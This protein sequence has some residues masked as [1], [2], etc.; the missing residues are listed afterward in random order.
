MV[1]PGLIACAIMAAPPSDWWADQPVVRHELPAVENEAW[2]RNGIDHFIL[3][4]LEA[5]ELSPPSDAD[6]RTLIRRA[7]YDLTGLPPSPEAVEA[8]VADDRPDAYERLIEELLASPQYGVKWG[9]H[10]LDRVRW[11][12]TDGYERD[13]FKPGA[14]RYRDWVVQAFNEDM[15]YDRFITLQLAGDE[16]PDRDFSTM[17]ATGFL[18]LGIRDDEPTDPETAIYDDLDGM[19]DTTC[20]AT[21]AI[22]MGCAR[23]HD[24][25]KD[26]IPQADYYRMLSFFRGL[27]P[28]RLGYGNAVIPAHYVRNL[29]LNFGNVDSSEI[30]AWIARQESLRNEVTAMTLEALESQGGAGSIPDIDTALGLPAAGMLKH[31]DFEG[32]PEICE[33]G[34][35]GHALLVNA[36]ENSFTIPRPVQND[37]TISFSFRP[38]ADGAGSGDP[39][40]FLGS[41]LVD[42]EISGIVND[43]GISWFKGGRVTAGVGNPETFLTSPAGLELGKWHHAALTRNRESGKVQLWVDG[44]L[45]DEKIGGK[46]S[47]D[48]PQDLA[49]GRMYPGGNPFPGAIDE[50]RIYDRVLTNRELLSIQ[51]STSYGEDA[52]RLVEQR[53][54]PEKADRFNQIYEERLSLKRPWNETSE[55]LAAIEVG[56]K[57]PPTHRLPRGN[58]HNPAEEVDPAVPII[59]GGEVLEITPAAHGDSTGRRL[60]LAEWITDPENPRTSRV[61]ANRMWQHH[62]GRGIA[63]TPDD[64]GK[65]G[66]HPT[67]PELLDWL[68]SQAIEYQWGMKDMHRLMMTS[69]TYRMGSSPSEE[70]MDKD[71]MNDLFSRF[72]MRRLTAEEIRDSLLSV[73]GKLNMGIGG[74][75]VYPPLPEEVLATA[76]RPD[77]AWK[78]SPENQ[79][80]RRS[81]YVHVKRSLKMPLLETFDMADTDSACPVR[82]NTT[83]PTQALTM[84]NSDEL[85][86]QADRLLKRL[87]AETNGSPEAVIR[88]GLALVTQEPPHAEDV[89]SCLALMSGLESEGLS[90]KEALHYTCLGMLNLNAF[91]YID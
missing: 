90:R 85:N 83:V 15:P 16:V 19:L 8:F 76:S 6:R 56:T 22:S 57:A 42:G 45:V 62:F 34:I 67:H 32:D 20:R 59:F 41:G 60:A 1:I 54:N 7:T 71:P 11:A 82:F 17:V 25:K 53:L 58:P 37:F 10:W 77:Q 66:F 44:E 78:P 2:C 35:S 89:S 49:V 64:F 23:C 12:E 27:K 28:Y 51:D 61:L 50:I 87:L 5:E 74:E 43:F 86:R 14:W 80:S 21:L 13:R 46:Q 4:R 36:V 26:P 52:K 68:A 75:S 73:N 29:P 69:S 40:W 30:E 84:L 88:R 3:A 9:R 63:R 24:H 33:A 72:E 48:A 70:A 81:L 55:I 65:L 18:H 31:V 91:M 39:R 79:A 38:D 47:L